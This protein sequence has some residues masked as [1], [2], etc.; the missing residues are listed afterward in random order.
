VG[1]NSQFMPDMGKAKKA[2]ASMFEIL[3]SKD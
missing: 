1:Q 3:D 2:G